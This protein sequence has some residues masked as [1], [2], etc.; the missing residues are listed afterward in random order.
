MAP[1]THK[2][3]ATEQLLRR[4]PWSPETAASA[5]TDSPCRGTRLLR[6]G[7]SA[8]LD[9]GHTASLTVGSAWATLAAKKGRLG[10]GCL[11]PKSFQNQSFKILLLPLPNP[12]VGPRG[13]GRHNAYTS[14][15]PLH[16]TGSPWMSGNPSHRARQGLEPNT[17]MT[18]ERIAAGSKPLGDPIQ[19]PPFRK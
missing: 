5:W 12:N 14:T 16:Q 17:H 1:E 10:Q 11:D 3:W 4:G 19:H 2:T 15:P 6:P 9:E 18:E 7:D 13:V 8:P